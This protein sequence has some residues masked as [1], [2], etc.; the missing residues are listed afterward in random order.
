[1]RNRFLCFKMCFTKGCALFCSY[2]ITHGDITELPP[3]VV[4]HTAKLSAIL[5]AFLQGDAIKITRIWRRTPSKLLLILQDVR[6]ERASYYLPTED[7]KT[8]PLED[9]TYK[10]E[11]EVPLPVK[12]SHSA[13]HKYPIQKKTKPTISVS[14][15]CKSHIEGPRGAGCIIIKQKGT[16]KLK[17]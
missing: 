10:K 13:K 17:V 5:N 2:R 8:L 15:M 14:I 4:N 6:D 9:S 3:L 16:G 7:R 1:M 12:T 11:L